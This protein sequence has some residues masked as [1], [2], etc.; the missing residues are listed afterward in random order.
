MCVCVYVA[1]TRVWVCVC[2]RKCMLARSVLVG[3]IKYKIKL[4]FQYTILLLIRR[5][6]I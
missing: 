1:C 6:I 3:I 5:S 4:N 2:A